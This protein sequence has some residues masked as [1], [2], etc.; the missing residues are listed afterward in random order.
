LRYKKLIEEYWTGD[1]HPKT[2][3]QTPYGE[4]VDEATEEE[5]IIVVVE[6]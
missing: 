5:E 4:Q 1:K 3:F 2:S 6:N